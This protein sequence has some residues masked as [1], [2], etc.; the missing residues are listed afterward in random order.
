MDVYGDLGRR[1]GEELGPPAAKQLGA[2]HVFEHEPA[3]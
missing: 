3:A 1:E 2:V